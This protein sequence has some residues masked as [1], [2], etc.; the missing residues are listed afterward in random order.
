M[1]AGSVQFV[2]PGTP[3]DLDNCDREPLHWAGAIQPH[4]VLVAC[5]DAPPFAIVRR[6]AN[7][8]DA[9]TLDALLGPDQAAALRAGADRPGAPGL[10]P[11]RVAVP[12]D[13]EPA[14]E[15]VAYVADPGTF[16]VELEPAGDDSPFERAAAAT[17]ALAGAGSVDELLGR[18]VTALRE[19]TGYDRVWAYRFEPDGHGVVV[20]EDAMGGLES[21]LGLHYP[22]S[23]IP[24][25]A[26][27]LFL[28][29]AVRVIADVEAPPLA[30]VPERDPDSGA[31]L[32]L[33]DSGLRAV[34]PMH[35]H[36][37]R[38][39]GVRASMSVALVVDGALWGLLSAHHYA[40]PHRPSAMLR[41]Q[42]GLLGQ[43]AS[44]Q[45]TLLRDLGDTEER[46]GLDAAADR[47]LAGV[48]GAPRI[49]AALTE[50]GPDL[51]GVAAA[52]GALVVLGGDAT[53][54]GDVPPA[55]DTAGLVALLAE[56]LAAEDEDVVALDDLPHAAPDL[57]GAG[58]AATG[59]LA[60][61]LAPARGEW[62]VWLRG[63][64]EHEVTWGHRDKELVRRSLSGEL[65]LGPRESYERWSEQA[66]GRARPWSAAERG[67]AL[68]FRQALGTF[69]LE[70][71]EQLAALNAELERSNDELETFA[72]AAAH[73]LQEPLRG[74]HNF[75]SFVLEDHGE[76]LGDDGRE[77]TGT[78]VRL[79]ERSSGLLDALLQYARVGRGASAPV[80]VRLSA[81]VDDVRRLLAGQIER[82]GADVRV[83]ADGVVRIDPSHLEQLLLNLVG[84]ALKYGGTDPQVR[85]A[86]GAD[87]DGT[88]VL[89]VEDDGI[90]IAPEHHELVFAVFRRLHARDQYQGGTGTGLAIVKR[91]AE[92]YRGSAR[93]VSELGRGARFEVR[94]PGDDEAA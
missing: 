39:M 17:A 21:F 31:W 50:R 38:A 26:R 1:D 10:R 60:I 42:A 81:A 79:A 4:G 74:I 53:P 33:S 89:S 88:P 69:V 5:A 25:Q 83:V 46:R 27:A 57:P 3:I 70:R 29:N 16:V 56:R 64:W 62:V 51:L 65:E 37:L 58:G 35:V 72:F 30:I 71:A 45:L 36:Y 12:A 86:L 24:A 61:P 52:N 59:V 91:I 40:G 80:D 90:G 78:I 87:P 68:R 15:A 23:D 54:V 43:I 2:L 93:V 49:G 44:M 32:D 75:A 82:V 48:A 84:N 85:V 28:R 55:L 76:A 8:P 47:V 94:L 11:V 18:A 6:S 92:R 7:A 9:G 34:S 67:A 22:A 19:L 73:D 77:L 14:Y 41:A 63:A 20:A 66:E 13:A